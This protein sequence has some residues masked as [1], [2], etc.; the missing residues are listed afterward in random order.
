MLINI[1]QSKLQEWEGGI[2]TGNVFCAVQICLFLKN[3]NLIFFKEQHGIKN[4]K[5]EHVQMCC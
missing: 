1:L 3:F 5:L 4:W 2:Q